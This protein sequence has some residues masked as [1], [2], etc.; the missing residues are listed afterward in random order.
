MSNCCECG[1]ELDF[2]TDFDN[3][4]CGDCQAT[5]YELPHN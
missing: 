3:A 2:E 4:V 5:L 1:G